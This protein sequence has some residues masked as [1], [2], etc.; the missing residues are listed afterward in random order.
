MH[1]SNSL[2]K[3]LQYIN[4]KIEIPEF[5]LNK[6]YLELIFKIF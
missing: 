4:K 1:G 2:P 3:P 5:S 6:M